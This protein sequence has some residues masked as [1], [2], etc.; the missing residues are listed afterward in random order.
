MLQDRFRFFKLLILRCPS[1]SF[2]MSAVQHC[3][4]CPK[5][6]SNIVHNGFR[7][8]GL[9][10]PLASDLRPHWQ[11]SSASELF[12]RPVRRAEIGGHDEGHVVD[13]PKDTA[14]QYPFPQVIPQVDCRWYARYLQFHWPTPPPSLIDWPRLHYDLRTASVVMSSNCGAPAV[15]CESSPDTRSINPRQSRA[16]APLRH[17]ISRSSP[18]SSCASFAPSGTPSV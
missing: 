3:P 7:A 15:N 12:L 2:A 17:L 5:A 8:R 10:R 4:N 16:T 13:D 18:K 6:G 1:A 11:R 14:G 9:G